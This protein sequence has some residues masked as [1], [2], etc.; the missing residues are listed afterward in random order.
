MPEENEEETEETELEEEKPPVK[1]KSKPQATIVQVDNHETNDLLRQ[2]IALLAPAT[3]TQ[4]K[5]EDKPNGDEKKEGTNNEP[6]RGG[7][8]LFRNPFDKR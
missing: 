2:V 5:E 4:T 3:P 7:L 1:K 6:K 8:K